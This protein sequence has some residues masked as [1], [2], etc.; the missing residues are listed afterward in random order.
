MIRNPTSLHTIGQAPDLHVSIVQHN[1]L[2]SWDLFLSLFSS[3][4]GTLDADI[5]LLQ[6]PPSSKGFLPRFTGFTS[7]APPNERPKVAIYV[8]LRFC[9]NYPILPGFH[10]D[11]TDTMYLDVYTPDG[12]FGTAA[13]KF[14]LNN[15]YA[16]E[17]GGHSRSVSPEIAFQQTDF[18]YLVAG[19]FNIHNPASDPLR[20][21]SYS[22]ELESA[23][24]YSLA[25]DRGFR[26][27]NTPGIYTRFPLSGSHRPSAIDLAFSNPL[28]SPAFAAWDTTSLPSTGS[29]HVPIH[30]TL[31]PPTNKPMPRVPCWDLT[32]WERLRPRLQAFCTPPA[33][34]SPSRPSST[35]GAHPR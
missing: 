18:P 17:T 11:T 33:P 25:S 23:P 34:P 5:V 22:E 3:L 27:L 6:D 7:F 4:V 35:N 13:P 12:C 10:Y 31:A 19:D 21:F 30:I 28:M 15:I 14:R 29:D 2:G 8:S 1:S 16:R 32:N 20:L 26:L 9:S 24:F